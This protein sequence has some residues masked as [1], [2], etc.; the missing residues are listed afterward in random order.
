MTPDQTA[1]AQACHAGA[2]EGRM[3]F[4]TILAT[5]AAMDFEGYLVDLR[6]GT[7]RY[8]LTGG[9]SID[10]AGPAETV[11]LPFD[12]PALQSAIRAAQTG[13]PGYTYAGFCHRA[14]QAGCAGYLVS[15]PG[16]R[17]LY[18]GRSAE[19][20]VEHFPAVL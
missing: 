20:H 5:L 3:T 14:A 9:D 18:F 4:P 13:G 17:V 10:C 19:T 11:D 7:A 8:F 16:R 1:T 6:H 15:L 2:T 12:A